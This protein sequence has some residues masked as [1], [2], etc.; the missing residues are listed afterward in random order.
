MVEGD[1]DRFYYL[2]L[3]EELDEGDFD[4]TSWE[5]GFLNTVLKQTHISVKQA[6]VLDEMNEKY[7]GEE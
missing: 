4:V 5:A 1:K 3:A 2:D 6:E 7:L